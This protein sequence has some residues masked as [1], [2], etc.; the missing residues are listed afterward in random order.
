MVNETSRQRPG[1]RNKFHA[2]FALL[3]FGF[4]NVSNPHIDGELAIL[5]MKEYVGNIH[6]FIVSLFSRVPSI[7]ILCRKYEENVG[8]MKKC[9]PRSWCRS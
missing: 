3:I 7:E 9:T 6:L 2:R 5:N 1:D 4:L 8:N